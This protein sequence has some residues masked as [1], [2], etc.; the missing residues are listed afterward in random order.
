MDATRWLHRMEN[1]VSTRMVQL[2]P[3]L[4]SS[5]LAAVDTRRVSTPYLLLDRRS[6]G[7]TDGVVGNEESLP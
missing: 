4:L 5:P 1:D 3:R 2:V 6:C 7:V